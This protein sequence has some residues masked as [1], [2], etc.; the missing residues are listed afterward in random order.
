MALQ[1]NVNGTWKDAAAVQVNVGG[2]WK[3]A[4][5]VQTNVGGQWKDSY[6]SEPPLPLTVYSLTNG[7]FNS[8]VQL[9]GNLEDVMTGFIVGINISSVSNS[10]LYSLLSSGLPDQ[11]AVTINSTDTYT[12]NRN[13]VNSQIAFY[14][15]DSG[16][17][18]ISNNYNFMY[19]PLQTMSVDV[20]NNILYITI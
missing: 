6:L 18:E 2:T 13:N 16:W 14:P 11:F 9:G 3:Q 15:A 8:S 10:D 12:V 20:E 17:N 1:V 4:D 7:D 5:A 19:T